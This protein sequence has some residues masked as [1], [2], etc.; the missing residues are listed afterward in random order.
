[1]KKA[2]E[3]TGHT[4][5]TT[6]WGKSLPAASAYQWKAVD[7][8]EK[9]KSLTLYGICGQCMQSDCTTLI[10][11]EDGVVVSVEGNPTSPPNYGS[12]CPRGN[13]QIMNLYNPYRVKTPLV[14]TNPEK[15]LD[16]DPMWK[17][18]SWDEALNIIVE[19]FK[20]IR[21]KDPRGLLILEG[22]GNT[23]SILRDSF[24]RAFGTPNVIGSHGPLCTIHYA[25]CLVHSA[26]PEAVA[27]MEYCEYLLSFGRSLGPNFATTGGIRRF[28]KAMERGMKL[29]VIDPHCSVEAS[30]G[31]WIPIRPGSDLACLLAMAHVML[32]EG[33]PYD[34]WFMKNRTN[35]PY[36]IN[37]EGNYY[38]DPAT[39]KPMIWD[40]A[41]NCARTFDSEFK[42]IAMNGT[43]T[44]NGVA[45]RTA[46]DLIREEFA[47]YTPEWA[48]KICTVPAKT[49]RRLATEFV[50]HAKIGSTIKI[51][52]F[53]FPFRPASVNTHRGVNCH[54]GGTYA[55]L[56]GKIMNMLVG[57]IE[58]PGGCL[59][60]SMRGPLMAPDKDGIVKP[61]FEADPFPFKFPPDNIDGHE[62]YPNKHTT[63]HLAINAIMNPEKYH[64]GYK[65]E[66]WLN[67][68][69]NVIRKNAQPERY[70]EA[71]KKVPFIVSFAYHIDEPTILADVVLPEHSAMERSL[72]SVLYPSHQ[73]TGGEVIG[74]DTVRVRQPV[75]NLFD[76]RHCDDIYTEI[77]E[78][79]GFLCGAGGVYDYL[80]Q[81][82]HHALIDD[83]FYLG[84]QKLDINRKHSL[85]EIYDRQMKSWSRGDGR[86][87]EELN[88]D[89]FFLHPRSRKEYYTYYF[90]PEN[91]T[92]HPFYFESLK[93]TGETLRANLRM[94][95]LK[96]PGIENEEYIWEQYRPIPC[97]IENS[98][99]NAPPEYDL[100]VV[101]WKSPYCPH[102]SGNPNGNPWLAELYQQDPFDFTIFLNSATAKKKGLKDRDWITVESRYG[103]TEGIMRV[104][105]L[106]HPDAVG[107]PGSY[108][109]GTI[110]S[111]P[112]F[113]EGTHFNALLSLDDK[114]LDAIAA[115]QELSPRVKVY[116]SEAKR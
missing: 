69:G 15:G 80:N 63:P 100:W 26:L 37:S 45:C 64:I 39:G 114:T 61:Q 72:V 99:I 13:S 62:F 51:D 36:L 84:N 86:G 66:A 10:H 89:G 7:P 112:I 56:T 5:K 22:F 47:R 14:R 29:V 98:E 52:D 40:A 83:G 75:P 101:N 96:F 9:G 113:R 81:Q 49:I 20:K 110:Q 50:E 97:W 34:E 38:R 79:V 76:T 107:I 4:Q 73:T 68:G 30:K 12:L 17:E 74:F 6:S 25:S 16:V 27:E 21:E 44:V 108:G 102:D 82:K 88:K 90:F 58:V 41:D 106:I 57:N 35:A 8:A 105:E 94:H 91:K 43:Y 19:K 85:D 55:D 93:K 103:K 11:L 104:T 77:A 60:N 48:E 71:M 109:L 53:V 2:K 115:G 78:R 3:V 46:F 31:E 87:L 18:V 1:M 42:D 95:N 32:N 59:G 33:L 24:A 28:T 116:K 65:I 111:N 54:R 70:V 92:R 67:F 23:N